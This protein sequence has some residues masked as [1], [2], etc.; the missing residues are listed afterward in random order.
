MDFGRLLD[1]LDKTSAK[2]LKKTY[3]HAS[4]AFVGGAFNINGFRNQLAPI[5]K[6]NLKNMMFFFIL[7]GPNA[8]KN[9][10]RLD[11]VKDRDLDESVKKVI[12][13]FMKLPKALEDIGMRFKFSNTIGPD[14]VTMSR[15]LAAFPA[16]SIK[17]MKNCE[18]R[19]KWAFPL[20]ISDILAQP[21]LI[22]GLM[23]SANVVSFKTDGK[24]KE[25][26]IFKSFIQWIDYTV[27]SKEQAAVKNDKIA[28]FESFVNEKSR[29][30][31]LGINSVADHFN[32]YVNEKK[33][34]L[35]DMENFLKVDGNTV[36]LQKDVIPIYDEFVNDF[37]NNYGQ[38]IG[39]EITD[40]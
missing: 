36:I 10:E 31:E 30:V 6:E 2:D 28:D 39:E 15:L 24:A 12:E 26:G 33:S 23:K 37:E 25:Y 4:M 21:V 3:E 11:D 32:T 16:F 19:R 9:L 1:S 38:R 17:V 35:K 18:P 34:A 40:D 7:G 8:K 20:L 22:L 27:T 5:G 13:D 29:F 14:V